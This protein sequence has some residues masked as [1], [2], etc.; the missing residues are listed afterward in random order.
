MSYTVHGVSESQTRRSDL[1]FHSVP[2]TMLHARS[3]I[4]SCLTLY[5]PMDCTLQASPSMGFSR[6]EYW[7]GLSFPSPGHLPDPGTKP[8][9]P[10]LQADSL[11]L[12][13]QGS[14]KNVIKAVNSY[15][16]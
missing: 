2:R 16:F 12:N 15:K 5:N 6:Q 11:P 4:R 10:A 9:S 8:E 1:H 14:P 3:V 13:H 7:S